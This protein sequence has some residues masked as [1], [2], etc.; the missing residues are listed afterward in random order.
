MSRENNGNNLPLPPP[1]S[2]AGKWDVKVVALAVI[3]VVLA[4]GLVSLFA[5]YSQPN[6]LQAQI[7]EKNS[8]ISS[9][10]QNITNLQSNYANQATQIAELNSQV[11]ALNATLK[12]AQTTLTQDATTIAEYQNNTSV[13]QNIISL[14]SSKVLVSQQLLKV[15]N[16]NSTDAYNNALPYAGYIVVQASSTSNTT[17]VQTSY[18]VDSVN[19]NQTVVLGAIG[20]EAFPVL[21]S[22]LE[23]K[24]GN[25]D[26]VLS[27]FS[28]STVTITYYY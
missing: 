16:S 4:A 14:N 28:N 9:L 1:P 21:P 22:T 3:C 8:Q 24:M 15:A 11:T 19:F 26:P 13:Y 2:S 20:T 17:Y 6:N 27:S 5:V 25:L 10:Q 23:V 7:T 12:Q 18:S